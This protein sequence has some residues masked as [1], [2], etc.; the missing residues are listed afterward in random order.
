[1]RKWVLWAPVLMVGTMLFWAVALGLGLGTL[2][3]LALSGMDDP[4]AWVGRDELRDSYQP[5]SVQ[6]GVAPGSVGQDAVE[7]SASVEPAVELPPATAGM[8]EGTGLASGSDQTRT[9][10]RE[11]DPTEDPT[12]EQGPGKTAF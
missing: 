11:W 9:I 5:I 8:D 7:A 12:Q 4:Q 1:M 2:S 3:G 10:R 6:L